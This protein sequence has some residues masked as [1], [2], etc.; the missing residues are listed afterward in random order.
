M[1]MGFWVGGTTLVLRET[2]VLSNL[3]TYLHM[4][5]CAMFFSQKNIAQGCQY[6]KI[7]WMITPVNI[8]VNGWTC[9]RTTV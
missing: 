3:C 5:H 7:L 4:K 8:S 1:E 9:E 2:F 6:I